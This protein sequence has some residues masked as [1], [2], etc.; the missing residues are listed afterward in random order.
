MYKKREAEKL[1]QKLARA[2]PV[3]AVTGPRQS[4]KT[5]LIRHLFKKKRYVSLEDLDQRSL[6]LQDPRGFLNQHPEG[7][8][9]DE[10][11]NVPELFSYLQGIVD[12]NN[13]PGRF[14]ITGSRQ[15]NLLSKITQ[16]LAGRV[17][18]VELLPF[19][20]KETGT[21]SLNKT[22]YTGL[23]PPL[24][25]KKIPPQLW[26]EDYVKTYIERDVRTLLGIRDLNL[27]QKFL[28]LCAGRVGG[29]LNYSD[30]SS[31]TG[32]DSRTIKS[33]IS[34]LEASYVIFLLQPHHKK[35]SKKLVKS[36]KLYFYDTG[37]LCYL[38]RIKQTEDLN[39]SPHKGQV[40]ESLILSE[41]M[42]YNKN[43]RAGLDFYFWRDSK[44]VE[45]DL[46]I[47]SS[48]YLI[49]VELK[50]GQTLN[51]WFFKNLNLYQKYSGSNKKG[52]LVYGGHK[53][54]VGGPHQVLP[55]YKVT[56]VLAPV[57]SPNK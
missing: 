28:R 4:G 30:L 31:A 26:Y 51:K 54:V 16:S 44:G 3:V 5:T 32:T 55:W 22:L 40:F 56:S 9:I 6:A 45:I 25:N 19:S 49:P 50:S 46:L 12:Q 37:V 34:I 38:L 57:T 39:I 8:L 21:R 10:I 52:V 29:L 36:P 42:K 24:Y 1:I 48:R 15:F 47:E 20:F 41:C 43:H 11:Q 23:Y 2:Y 27:F 18:L 13:T 33:W 35:F 17:G 53:P 14:I 7:L